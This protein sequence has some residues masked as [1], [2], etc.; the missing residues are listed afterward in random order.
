M[1]GN[2]LELS[3]DVRPLGAADLERVIA[4]DQSHTGFARRRFFEKR[5]QAAERQRED[6]IHVGVDRNGTLIGFVCARILHGEFGREEPVA[7]LDSVGV[8]PATQEHG[9][10]HTLLRGLA[11]AM[12]ERGVRELHSE[13]EWTNHKLLEFFDSTGFALAPRITLERRVNEPLVEPI[14]DS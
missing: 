5:F 11:K 1:G 2:K 13:A 6:F 8:D 4:I 10:G 3:A 12:R 7:E 14:E 9:H